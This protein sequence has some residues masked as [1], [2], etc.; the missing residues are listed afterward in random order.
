[1]KKLL[2]IVVLLAAA[3]SCFFRASAQERPWLKYITPSGYM[4]GGFSVDDSFN[5]T[6]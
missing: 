3:N 4:Q 5:N 6:F 1:M 2:L